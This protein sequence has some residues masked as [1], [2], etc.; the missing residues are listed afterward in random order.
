MPPAERSSPARSATAGATPWAN[1]LTPNTQWLTA[2]CSMNTTVPRRRPIIHDPSRRCHGRIGATSWCLMQRLHMSKRAAYATSSW[3]TWTVE[4]ANVPTST[5]TTV[6]GSAR[7][8]VVRRP[9]DRRF[10]MGQKTIS[11]IVNALR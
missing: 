2:A 8:N 4:S 7:R 1:T 10:T 9:T 6:P 11:K 3:Q 5:N